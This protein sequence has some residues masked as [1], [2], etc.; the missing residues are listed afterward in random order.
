MAGIQE[1][2]ILVVSPKGVVNRGGRNYSRIKACRLDG[3]PLVHTVPQC[4]PGKQK[5]DDWARNSYVFR[6]FV[7]FVNDVNLRGRFMI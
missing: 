4:G 6:N 3:V 7:Q 1:P 2:N 5:T